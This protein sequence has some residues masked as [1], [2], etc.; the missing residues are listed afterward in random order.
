MFC[1]QGKL[2]NYN[3]FRKMFHSITL[4]ISS[5]LLHIL[6]GFVQTKPVSKLSLNEVPSVKIL[7]TEYLFHS[8]FSTVILFHFNAYRGKIKCNY[9][10]QLEY[11]TAK[12]TVT[13][14]ILRFSAPR[15]CFETYTL[16]PTFTLHIT[17]VLGPRKCIH[18]Y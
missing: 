15:N 14:G 4:R 1:V 7:D 3:I 10:S 18:S 5:L 8:I 13:H 11:F 17:N 16:V 12:V 2:N 6:R 9:L